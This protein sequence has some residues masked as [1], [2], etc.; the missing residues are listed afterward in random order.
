MDNNLKII[1]NEFEK[2]KGQ[3]VITDWAHDVQRLIA[4]AEDDINYYYIF[5]DG[6]KTNWQSCVGSFIPLKGYIK[7]DDYNSFI[8]MAKLNH[9]DQLSDD[10]KSIKYKKQLKQETIEKSNKDKNKL[11]TEICWDIN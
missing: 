6:K 10:E 8:N 9:Y 3:F 1:L 11:L 4:I 2:H 5:W 7:N